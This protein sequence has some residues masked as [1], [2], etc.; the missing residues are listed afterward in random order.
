[1][2]DT[3]PASVRP[4]QGITRRRLLELGAGATAAYGL[5][6]AGCG[7][8]AAGGG[9]KIGGTITVTS[10]GGAWE[11]FVRGT[12]VPGFEKKHPGTKVELAIGL[13]KD[14]VAKLKAAG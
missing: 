2:R 7:A 3:L 14:W 12:V 4:M 9:D 10:Y 6:V 1:M 13:S 5:A 11:E 8:G